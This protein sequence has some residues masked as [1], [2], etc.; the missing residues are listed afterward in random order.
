M[1]VKQIRT[2]SAASLAIGAALLFG[3]STP[4][5]K[6]LVGDLPAL[7]LAGLLYLGSGVGL[8][9]VRIVRDRGWQPPALSIPEWLW[10]SGAIGFGGI[11][12]P[13]LLVLGLAKTG[14]GTASLLLNL[15]AVLTASLAWVVFAEHAGRRIVLGMGLIVAG[16]VALSWPDSAT[17]TSDWAGPLAIMG[18]CLCWAIDN[19]LTRKVSATDALFIAGMKGMVAGVVNLGLSLAL[20]AQI[21]AWPLA[22]AAMFIGL[23]GY[24]ISL[25]LFVRALRELGTSRTGAYFSIAPFTGAVLSILLFDEP[26]PPSFWLAGIMMGIGVW[27]H[28]TES[29]GHEHE[30]E[31]LTHAHVHVHDEHH[32]HNHDTTWDGLAPHSHAHTHAPIRHVH[33]H[34][35]DIHHRHSH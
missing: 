13:T 26:T 23:L 34:F 15:E 33:S 18:A 14:A 28:L 3:A 7:T 11:L 6:L 8:A 22:G 30:H 21:P 32:Q 20:G 10:F 2:A 16:S 17:A 24:G 4:F 31:V 9:T 19:N 25:V 5:V 29:H 1:L 12:G 35:P 27:L